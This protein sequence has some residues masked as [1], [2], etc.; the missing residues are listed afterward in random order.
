[1]GKILV[2]VMYK[3]R[4]CFLDIYVTGNG[5]PQLLVSKGLRLLGSGIA[6][7]NNVFCVSAVSKLCNEYSKLFSDELGAFN[8]F[9]VYLKIRTQLLSFTRQGLC[10]SL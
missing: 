9:Q 6:E 7:I 1:M 5:G 8:K 2:E 3:N 4:K 10:I